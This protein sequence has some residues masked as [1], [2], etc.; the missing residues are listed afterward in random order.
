MDCK[1]T[2]EGALSEVI[3]NRELE[4]PMRST[5]EKINA[6]V[7]TYVARSSAFSYIN[8]LNLGF[9]S[10]KYIEGLEHLENL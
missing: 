2:S 5:L 6:K 3:L 7:I 1:K 9:N 8:Y 10:I 4:I